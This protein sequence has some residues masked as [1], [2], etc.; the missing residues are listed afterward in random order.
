MQSQLVH[1]W[2]EAKPERPCILLAEDDLTLRDLLATALQSDG[3]RVLQVGT[4]NEL[5]DEVK[6]VLQYGAEG[7]VIDLLVS[8]VRMPKLSGLVA[9]KMLRDAEVQVPVILIS[10]FC[11]DEL[12]VQAAEWGATLIEKPIG[13]QVFRAAVRKAVGSTVPQ[14][15][16]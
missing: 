6:R 12:R 14:L 4:G 16:P 1:R 13:L 11:D 5:I 15:V 10:A 8:D 3:H 9:L 2:A 7:G